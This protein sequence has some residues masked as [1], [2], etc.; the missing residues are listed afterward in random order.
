MTSLRSRF[1]RHQVI[2]HRTGTM[3]LY[4]PIFSRLLCFTAFGYC[5]FDLGKNNQNINHD[6]D[7]SKIRTVAPF[8]TFVTLYLSRL[9]FVH[10]TRFDWRW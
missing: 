1:N 4:A 2:N 8:L 6:H 3:K 9:F 10:N 5:A 7:R